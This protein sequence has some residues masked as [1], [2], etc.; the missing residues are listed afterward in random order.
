MLCFFNTHFN[1]ILPYTSKS[2]K[3]SPKFR[4]P[5]QNPTSIPSPPCVPHAPLITSSSDHP[6]MGRCVQ[7]MKLRITQFLPSRVIFILSEIN[8]FLSTP[9]LTPAANYVLILYRSTI[10][11]MHSN[12]QRHQTVNFKLRA[13]VGMPLADAQANTIPH[14][15]RSFCIPNQQPF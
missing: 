1:I 7:I 15:N 8:T 10:E 12:T 14:T 5:N 6:N 11:V 4:F 2:S 3:C 13:T 9:P